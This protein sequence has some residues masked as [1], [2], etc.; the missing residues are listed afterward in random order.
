MARRCSV[1]FLFATLLGCSSPKPIPLE[2]EYAGCG[3]VLL[4]GPLC[5][6]D[7]E[8]K[9]WLWAAAPGDAG[10]EIRVDGERIEAS[11]KEIQHGQGFSLTLPAQAKRL[12]VLAENEEGE[13]SWSL[14]LAE[15]RGPVRAS[16]NLLVHVRNQLDPVR[17][18]VDLLRPHAA[19]TALQAIRLHPKAPAE[20]FFEVQ[21]YRALLADAEG[22]FRSAMIDIQ[23]A[24][25]IAER[26][27]QE[28]YRWMAEQKLALLLLKLGRSEEAIRIFGR[29]S[30]EP[31]AWDAC[32]TAQCLG[33]QAWTM[34][35]ARER[36]EDHEDPGPLLRQALATYETCKGINNE[37]R[38]NILINM[39]LAHLQEDRLQQAKDVLARARSLEPD[40][41]VRL[42]LWWLHL[43]ARIALREGRPRE[44]LLRFGQ[45]GEL[46]SAAGSSDGRLR[47]LLGKAQSLEALGDRPAALQTLRTAEA[48]LDEE[49]L[50]V[51]LHEGRETFIATRQ[52]IVSLHLELLLDLERNAEALEVARHAR[53]RLLRH[54]ERSDSLAALP[55][56]RQADWESL[57]TEYQEKRAA[58]EERA[59]N[60]WKLPV[61]RRRREQAERK[62]ETEAVKR[63]LDEAFL[64]LESPGKRTAGEPPPAAGELILAYHPL[65]R[66]WV[67][68][69]ADGKEVGVHRFDL[70]SGLPPGE[71]SRRLL[72]RFQDKIRKAERVRI[73]PIGPLEKVDFHALPFDGDIL[74]AGRPVVYGL[75]L[76]VSRSPARPSSREALVVADP[77]DDLPGTLEEA[78]RVVEVLKS[79]DVEVLKSA[80]ASATAVSDRLVRADLVH[81]S[82]HSSYSGFG[83][84][85]SSLLLAESQLTLFD[86]LT[87]KRVPTWVVLSGC[88]S[89][90]SST[91]VPVESLGL[92]H[93]FLLAGSRAVIASVRLADDRQVSG[94][95][96]E[97]YRQWERE[98]DLSVAF[99]RAQLAWRRQAPAADWQGFRLFVP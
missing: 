45:L 21:Y 46:A 75:D 20:S 63:L 89:G 98:P 41:P 5:V 40:P 1:L 49:S 19:R 76:A 14:S 11:G 78:A 66:G 4:S 81:Y 96:P 25:R 22:D 54:L 95:F 34:L 94:F 8:R 28:R 91:E 37:N 53:T 26:T 47:A 99:Q 56:E 48:L 52:A 31:F 3:A 79:W 58:L 57:V 70:P 62:A 44:A 7:E 50:Q 9:L 82:G 67:G 23:E 27:R 85:E 77:R 87:L 73:L 86:L 69:A 10:L 83:G 42:T 6:L 36:G 15:P 33:N 68:F 29:L 18:N 55:R 61:D 74:M 80:E 30:R 13:A 65:S 38:V 51:P 64:L 93:A 24:V 97:L 90:R 17:E 39:A 12:D 35:L 72:L 2:V 59:R 84:W 71:L 32:E 16:S 60:D 88:E 43:E 92:A